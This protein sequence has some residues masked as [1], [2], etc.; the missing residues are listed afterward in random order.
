MDTVLETGKVNAFGVVSVNAEGPEGPT[1]LA[2]GMA[3]IES[4]IATWSGVE[5]VAAR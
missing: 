5:P 1:S 3:M 4:A 2:S